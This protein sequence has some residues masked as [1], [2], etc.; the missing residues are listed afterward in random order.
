MPRKLV[1]YW[2]QAT[3]VVSH[4]GQGFEVQNGKMNASRTGCAVGAG[5][6]QTV[7]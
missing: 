1:V 2:L 4:T 6:I 5:R 7:E 3:P